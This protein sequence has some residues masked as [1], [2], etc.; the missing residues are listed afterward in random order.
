MDKEK[1]VMTTGPSS[2]RT[3]FSQFDSVWL[4]DH[5]CGHDVGR[6]DGLNVSNMSVNWC[7]KQHKLQS[8]IIMQEEGFLGPHSPKLKVGD[9]EYDIGKWWW[10]S[11]FMPENLQ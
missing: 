7:G 9:T 5:S 6:E 10:G 8:T 3:L 4:F 11:F 2:L 1:G